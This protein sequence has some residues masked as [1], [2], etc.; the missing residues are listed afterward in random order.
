MMIGPMGSDTHRLA[1][2]S[3]DNVQG[4]PILLC[5]KLDASNM[6]MDLTECGPKNEFGYC[7]TKSR[8]LIPRK[9]RISAG[10]SKRLGLYG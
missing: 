1:R 2:R 6:G 7:R 8:A 4:M 3:M 10:Q 9:M 5:V